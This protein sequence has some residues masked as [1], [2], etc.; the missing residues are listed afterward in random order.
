MSG[1][2]SAVRAAAPAAIALLVVLFG[3]LMQ[4]VPHL[5]AEGRQDAITPAGSQ[6]DS[7][8]IRHQPPVDAEI[9]DVF[10]PPAHIGAPGNRGLEYS[11]DPG[12]PVWASAG[13]LVVFAGPVA[14]NRFV[15]VLHPDGLRSS[16]GYLRWI[17]VNEGDRVRG[18]QLLGATSERFFF[19]VRAGDAY[20]DPERILTAGRVR[21]LAPR[22][23][24]F[25]SLL[26]AYG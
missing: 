6:P 4:T 2:P 1:D 16:Y 15:T 9:V 19:S 13:G 21:L 3:Q 25:G 14:G 22:A 11:P 10:R 12:Q 18:G 24:D 20:L 5:L 7:P 26:S 17:A 23:P 8:V